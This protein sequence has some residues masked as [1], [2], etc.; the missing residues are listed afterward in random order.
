MASHHEYA[1]QCYIGDV[2]WDAMY[3]AVVG[4]KATYC[5]EYDAVGNM[6]RAHFSELSDATKKD[7]D[8]L[9]IKHQ[10]EYDEI[11][12]KLIELDGRVENLYTCKK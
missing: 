8:A 10:T 4:K 12:Q 6:M 2:S 3:D 1:P 7:T 11:R 5:D 9:K